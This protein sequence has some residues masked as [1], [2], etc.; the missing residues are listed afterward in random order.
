MFFFLTY[1]ALYNRLQ[2]HPL[3]YNWFKCILF[4]G[5][6]IFHRVYVSQISYPFVCWWTSRLLPGPGYCKQ[7]CDEHWGARVSFN[8]G[9]LGVYA[10]QWDCW[11]YG[12]S[13]SSFLRNLHTALHSGCTSL[14]SHQQCKRWTAFL[15]SAA[16][17]GG[18][19][20]SSAIWEAQHSSDTRTT[21]M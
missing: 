7:C 13:I 14:H 1:F 21:S 17:A 10:Q 12:S 3:R 19:L 18:F 16:L 20:T 4:N 11:S 15:M 2:F 5:W 6:A 9:F 8:C